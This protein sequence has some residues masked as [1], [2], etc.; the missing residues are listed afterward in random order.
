MIH[1]FSNYDCHLLEKLIF[2]RNDKV[3]LDFLPKASEDDI[4]VS[5]GCIR[6]FDSYRILSM[7]LDGIGKTL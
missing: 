6:F 3:K 1:N 7:R 4:S 2:K 5:Y